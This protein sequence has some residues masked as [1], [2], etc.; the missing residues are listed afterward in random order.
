MCAWRQCVYYGFYFHFDL[1]TCLFTRTAIC[2]ITA[3]L[4]IQNAPINL[5]NNTPTIPY[6]I[7]W[8]ET[9]Y[10][11]GWRHKLVLIWYRALSYYNYPT[12]SQYF[13]PMAAQLSKKYA[14]PLAKIL[15]TAPC[16]SSKTGPIKTWIE[17][18][19][20]KPLEANGL[21]SLNS[22]LALIWNIM[23]YIKPCLTISYCIQNTYK[24]SYIRLMSHNIIILYFYLPYFHVS[25]SGFFFFYKILWYSPFSTQ[26]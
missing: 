12:L 6:C 14:L 24:Y 15:A 21:M 3:G 7:D 2:Q 11:K 1:L 16:R 25:N 22:D 4:H 9:H 17:D 10:I 8:I 18:E 26:T 23:P 13:Q 20:V 5:D 19:Y